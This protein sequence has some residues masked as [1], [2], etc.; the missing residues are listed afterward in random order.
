MGEWWGTEDVGDL[1]VPM[2]WVNRNSNHTAQLSIS[3]GGGGN[4]FV[5]R[6]AGNNGQNLICYFEFNLIQQM[7][8]KVLVILVKNSNQFVD[9][10]LSYLR[11][12][13]QKLNL[14]GYRIPKIDAELSWDVLAFLFMMKFSILLSLL[15][16]VNSAAFCWRQIFA[17]SDCSDECLNILAISLCAWQMGFP[18]VHDKWCRIEDHELEQ[19]LNIRGPQSRN[20]AKYIA[21]DQRYVNNSGSD[22]IRRNLSAAES[23]CY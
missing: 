1:V 4:N 10:N 16:L 15:W 14:I 18:R 2:T 22:A 12:K 3:G 7:I 19:L 8:N 23:D 21:I 17:L 13:C 9:Q 5:S 11:Y 6:A 20:G